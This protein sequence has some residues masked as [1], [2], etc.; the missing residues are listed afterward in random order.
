M[1]GP[2][3]LSI[4]AYPFYP[5]LNLQSQSK[6][7][8][9]MPNNKKVPRS[10]PS[11]AVDHRTTTH[12]KTTIHE[13]TTESVLIKHVQ[14]MP[15]LNSPLPQQTAASSPHVQ[16][17]PPQGNTMLKPHTTDDN[18]SAAHNGSS[19]SASTTTP[20][21]NV[22]SLVPPA[23]P[24]FGQNPSPETTSSN[25]VVAHLE[26]SNTAVQAYSSQT[27]QMHQ[28]MQNN[29]GQQMLRSHT[30]QPNTMH[31]TIQSHFGPVPY[32]GTL[33]HPNFAP[34]LHDSA[35]FHPQ[36]NNAQDQLPIAQT[37]PSHPAWHPPHNNNSFTFT[38]QPG[39]HSNI[40]HPNAP[41]LDAGRLIYINGHAVT[42]M[43]ATFLVAL[44]RYLHL[45]DDTC[46]GR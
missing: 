42:Q 31:P 46:T 33:L 25:L 5:L 29:R 45:D 18:M 26:P 37:L 21:A 11:A 28:Y 20:R 34:R 12:R 13:S 4:S 6:Q 38:N 3:N 24:H 35:P 16:G 2:V 10:S 41:N 1:K 22:E 40:I 39:Q 27:Q 32:D 15:T 23:Y 8:V 44:H 19:R 43:E 17:Q 9:R 36:L 7:Q 30:P 14:N